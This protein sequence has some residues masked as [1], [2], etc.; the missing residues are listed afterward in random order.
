M[1]QK[2]VLLLVMPFLMLPRPHLGVA[3]LKAVMARLGMSCDIRYLTFRFA[4]IIGAPLYAR[5]AERSPAHLLLG[6]FLFTPA[7]YG[8]DARPFSDFRA[9]IADYVLHY[10]EDFLRQLER[11]RNLTPAFIRECAD[12]IDFSRYDII[13]LTSSFEQNIAS[14][15]MAREIKR[16]APHIVTVFGG[17]NFESEMGVELH[18]CFPFIDVVCSGEG[19]YVFPELVRRI[20]AGEPLHDLGGVTCRV[21]GET[22]TSAAQQMFV[23]NLNDLPYPDHSDYYRALRSSTVTDM[24]APETT[25]ETS[26]GC[27]WGQ[28]HHCTFCGL[29]GLGMTYRSKTPERAYQ[30]IK[31]LLETYGSPELFNTDNIV[32]I[33][34]FSELFPRLAA[35]GYKIQLFYETKSNLKKNQLMSLW[36]V[37]GRRF[38]PGIESLSTHV[39]G[40]MD[41]GVKGIQNVQLLRWSEEIGFEVFWNIICGFPGETPDDYHHTTR[42]IK[43][44]THLPPPSVITRFRLDR[45]SPMFKWPEKYGIKNIRSY[46]GYRLC[47]PFP[48]DSI[49]R[50]AYYH[51]CDPPS[52]P[53]VPEAIKTSWEAVAEWQRVHDNST[54]KAEVTPE[55]LII[56]ERRAGYAPADYRFEGLAREVY[57]AADGVHSDL[58]IFETAASRH[59]E[60]RTTI[61]Q[62]RKILAEFVAKDLMLREE[63][64]Y[65]SLAVLPIDEKIDTGDT[66]ARR[67]AED[68]AASVHA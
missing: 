13:G 25:M 5:I 20:R 14:L 2:R 7:L 22:V 24:V 26:R 1:S 67:K 35:E 31:Y 33:R 41:K 18:R 37:G 48:E 29:N 43:A 28:K 44:V 36:S 4:E 6:E 12:E 46:I 9:S 68:L 15:A 3:L 10:S 63:N 23:S 54:L 60:D 32:D 55:S 21:N 61:E 11:T 45:F 17:A 27:W 57:L 42:W 62:V 58:V 16:R 30:E 52:L 8:E 64:L 39:L 34:Y 53:G 66:A 51:D 49:L 47:Y 65:L 38:V 40:L 19:D 50:L 59:P 56:H